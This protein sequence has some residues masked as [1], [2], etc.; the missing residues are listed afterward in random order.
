MICVQNVGFTKIDDLGG[1]RHFGGRSWVFPY[2]NMVFVWN[3]ARI[4]CFL[5]KKVS[6][7][8]ARVVQCI[9]WR[10]ESVLGPDCRFL[11]KTYILGTRIRWWARYLYIASDLE[12]YTKKKM[13]LKS[14]VLLA[15]EEFDNNFLCVIKFR[16]AILEFFVNLYDY[17][18]ILLW[19]SELFVNT[20]PFFVNFW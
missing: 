1:I 9:W 12:S 18:C 5:L 4:L 15:Q 10:N 8:F 7:T 17:S 13:F 11:Q 19:K 6:R 20:S 14:M 2:Q 3:V 16:H